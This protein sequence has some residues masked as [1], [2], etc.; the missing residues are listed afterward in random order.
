MSFTIS[1]TSVFTRPRVAGFCIPL[2]MGIDDRKLVSIRLHPE[3][4][5]RAFDEARRRKHGDGDPLLGPFCAWCV[6]QIVNLDFL[7][8]ENRE[9]LHGMFTELGR[10]WTL[11]DLVDNAVTYYRKEV[12]AGRLRPMFWSGQIRSS[13]KEGAR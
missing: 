10:P 2:Q 5:A 1:S 4:H 9:F 6:R 11:L 8:I 7:S 12:R 13:M 3:L